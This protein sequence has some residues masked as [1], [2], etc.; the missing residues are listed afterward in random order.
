METNR[1]FS[2]QELPKQERLT[3]KKTIEELFTKGSSVFVYPFRLLYL[4]KP[5]LLSE[6]PFYP[7]V[8]FSVSKKHF[9]RA[10]DRNLIKRR[11]REAYRLNKNNLLQAMPSQQIPA[12][13][14]LVYVAKE[15]I[16]F[17]ALQK[18]LKTVWQRLVNTYEESK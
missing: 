11:M 15:K 5:P 18:K 2:S 17:A 12:S 14:A 10:V 6:Q 16:E 7:Q 1:D 9:K 8:L 4:P 3:S 13:I